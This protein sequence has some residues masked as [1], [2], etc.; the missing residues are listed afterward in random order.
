M[1]HLYSSVSVQSGVV[2]ERVF[3]CLSVRLTN[4]PCC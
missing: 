3:V 1:L 4:V 2:T